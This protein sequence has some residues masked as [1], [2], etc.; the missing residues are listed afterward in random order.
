M[1][2]YTDN[3]LQSILDDINKGT[4]YCGVRSSDGYGVGEIMLSSDS[5]FIAY[6]H[7]GSSAVDSTI[8][9]LRFL[10]EKIF[11]DCAIIT[12]AVWSDYHIAYIP[13]DPQYKG[14]DCSREHPNTFGV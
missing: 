3:E 4:V 5:R 14:F 8:R 6:S 2:R 10:M 13:I 7:Y 11:D 9:G 1:K 12:P